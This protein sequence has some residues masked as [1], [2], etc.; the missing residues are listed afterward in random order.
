M[1]INNAGKSV[2]HIVPFNLP[3]NPVFGLHFIDN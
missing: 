3:R 2:I 1:V